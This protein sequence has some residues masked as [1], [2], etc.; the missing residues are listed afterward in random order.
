MTRC[1]GGSNWKWKCQGQRQDRGVGWA[2]SVAKLNL[3]NFEKPTAA[4][5]WLSALCILTGDAA[6]RR[7]LNG[8]VV[9]DFDYANL[10]VATMLLIRPES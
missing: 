1:R 4:S 10:S 9:F 7:T 2:E 6:T 3:H 8:N 5:K